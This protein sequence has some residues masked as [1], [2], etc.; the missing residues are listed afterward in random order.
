LNWNL[1][2]Q[3]A[4]QH[5]LVRDTMSTTFWMVLGKS[6]GFLIPFFIAAWFGVNR[7]TDS[8]F[9]VY[10]LVI[11]LSSSVAGVVVTIIVPFLAE[12]RTRKED[13]GAFVGNIL[14][15]SGILLLMITTVLIIFSDPLFSLLTRF[16]PATRRLTVSLFI[17]TAPLIILLFWSGLLSGAMNTYK[18]FALP[19]FSP[20]I[21]AV[22]IIIFIFFMKAKIGVHAVAIG[23]IIGEFCRLTFFFIAIRKWRLFRIKISLGIDARLKDFA[24]TALFQLIAMTIGVMNPFIDKIM[25]S[26]ISEGSVSVLHY[27]HMLYMIPT[28]ILTSGLMVTLLSHWSQR[29]YKN[30]PNQLRGDVRKALTVVAFW[31]VPLT[32]FLI[33]F[34]RPIVRLLFSWGH[35]DP[36]LHTQ[37]EWTWIGYL[38][39]LFPHALVLILANAYITMKNTRRIMQV[40]LAILVLNIGLNLILMPFFQVAGLALSTSGVTLV[41]LVCFSIAFSRDL[42][43]IESP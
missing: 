12:K 26:W 27:S 43:K 33:L 5:S 7:Q 11:F 32:G 23:Y 20:A 1:L 16:D 4:A 36:A 14:G 10:G 2:K 38:V 3:K 41:S 9:L 35:F 28:T 31:T 30:G 34:H 13:I 37:L 25:A 8:F 19:A 21:R 6:V 22:I 42:G 29:F 15:V 17:E 39:G 18:K 24:R 40:S